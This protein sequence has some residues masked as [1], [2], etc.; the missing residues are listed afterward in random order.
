MN[1]IL[2]IINSLFEKET[3]KNIPVIIDDV[4]S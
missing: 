1:L 2:V 3:Q 4:V